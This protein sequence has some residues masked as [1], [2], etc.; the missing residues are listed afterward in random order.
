M[1]NILSKVQKKS[2][3]LNHRD[4][5]NW[6][7]KLYNI[8]LASIEWVNVPFSIDTRFIEQTLFWQNK[9][10]WF[11]DEVLGELCLPV[12]NTSVFDWYGNFVSCRG[13]S[14]N[15]TSPMLNCSKWDSTGKLQKQ[16]A[17]IIY[18]NVARIPTISIIESYAKRLADID[19]AIDVNV[20]A[21]KTPVLIRCE[22]SE[23]LTMRNIYEQYEGNIPVIFGTQNINPNAISSINTKAEFVAPNL[24]ALRKQILQDC[25][26]YM[27]IESNVSEKSERVLSG[28]ITANMGQIESYR[29]TRLFPREQAVKTINNIF[30][31]NIEVRFRSNLDLSKIMEN[32]EVN[33]LS[34]LY[35]GGE[36]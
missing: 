7:T 25:L 28:E 30:G 34:K 16:N 29:Q 8:I 22:E 6:F 19:R 14:Y 26:A 1:V 15:Y 12:V 36:T 17:V 5:G 35:E 3:Y 21:Q 10:V 31:H 2:F 33:D 11:N 23:R 18:D 27:G 20:N 13:R 4:F 24:F 9:A 32:E